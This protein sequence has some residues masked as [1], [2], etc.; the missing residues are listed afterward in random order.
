MG[1]NGWRWLVLVGTM[2]SLVG[3]NGKVKGA[4][5]RRYKLLPWAEEG[6]RVIDH[7]SLYSLDRGTVP[8]AWIIQVSAAVKVSA[9]RVYPHA[10]LPW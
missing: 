7:V 8:F 1:G 10:C 2:V 9:A 4:V 3:F 6:D 5:P